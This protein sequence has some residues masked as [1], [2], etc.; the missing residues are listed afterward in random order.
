VLQQAGDGTPSTHDAEERS[1]NFDTL[2]V[3][4]LKERCEQYGLKK[5]GKRADLLDQ[6][7][8]ASIVRFQFLSGVFV[9]LACECAPHRAVAR[10][11]ALTMKLMRMYV[12]QSPG[13]DP[14]LHV[15]RDGAAER[16][17]VRGAAHSRPNRDA[18]SAAVG[19]ATWAG[20]G[21]KCEW[22]VL[23]A[24]PRHAIPRCSRPLMTLPD[25]WMGGWTDRWM[26]GWMDAFA[27][28]HTCPLQVTHN[29]EERSENF[30]T[31][32]VAQLKE[33]CEQYGLKKTGKRAD[34]L[35][36]LRQALYVRFQF[37][38]GVFV[39]LA[40]ECAPHRAIGTKKALTMKLM[41]RLRTS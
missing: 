36:Q 4:Q 8:Q 1:E 38:S 12:P 14:E 19:Y 35:D 30:D 9:Q 40:C 20:G 13:C 34:L 5:T 29:S 21:C 39:L 32:T 24:Q 6:L 37:L 41:R 11:K 22:R 17:G 18:H 28:I 15:A 10:K 26:D 7:K 16:A 2:T 23:P 27:Y 3:A 31:L 25:R 33:R